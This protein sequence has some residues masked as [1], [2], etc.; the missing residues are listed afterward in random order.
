MALNYFLFRLGSSRRFILIMK[1][2]C[3][4]F[5]FGKE[6]E[7]NRNCRHHADLKLSPLR[8]LFIF[9]PFSLSRRRRVTC[10]INTKGATFAWLTKPW[11]EPSM[12][13]SSG[14]RCR[15]P[16]AVPWPTSTL[17]IWAT[18]WWKPVASSPKSKSPKQWSIALKSSP[19]PPWGGSWLKFIGLETGTTTTTTTSQ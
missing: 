12:L 19:V 4:L 10:Y 11:I 17:T 6:E 8:Y 9:W 13:P 2:C 1:L 14:W 16:K 5:F 3:I 18:S 15:T 7:E